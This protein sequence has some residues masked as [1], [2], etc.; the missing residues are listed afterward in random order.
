MNFMTQNCLPLHT[1]YTT[2]N[3]C[4]QLP[5]VFLIHVLEFDIFNEFCSI[6]IQNND[7]VTIV[8]CAVMI[9]N[10]IIW[11]GED[12]KNMSLSVRWK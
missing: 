7:Y 10:Y 3:M 8:H 6:I 5:Y 2:P 12:N 1:E 11:G 4:S 9:S